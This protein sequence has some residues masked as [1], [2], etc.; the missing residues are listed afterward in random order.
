MSWKIIMI[1][2]II[3]LVARAPGYPTVVIVEKKL[4]SP[5]PSNYVWFPGIHFLAVFTDVVPV[6]T[7]AA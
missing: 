5:D 7:L 6:T 1:M 3:L 2:I 4:F